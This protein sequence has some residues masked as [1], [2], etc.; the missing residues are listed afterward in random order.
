MN[1]LVTYFRESFEELKKVT[2]PTRSQTVN[3]SL[4][5]VALS[6]LVAIFIGGLDYGLTYGIEKI[7]TLKQTTPTSAP[8][9]VT[10]QPIQV[11]PSDIQ[12]KT[13]PVTTPTTTPTK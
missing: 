13:E 4:A 6:L 12:V 1:K 5:V 3:Y 9:D 10:S 7:L 8:A 2:W 11:N